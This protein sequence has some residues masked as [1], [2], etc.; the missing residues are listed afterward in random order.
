LGEYLE[1]NTPDVTVLY[2]VKD[3]SEWAEF[4]DAVCR[5]YG[6][7]KKCCPLI[8]TLEGTF[9]GDGRAFVDHVTERYGVQ[10]SITKENNKNRSQINV[11]ENNERMRKKKDGDTLGV[12]I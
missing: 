4:V 12:K 10:L 2:A 9:I 5:S 3:N 7:S 11:D 1:K 8:Y 6:F